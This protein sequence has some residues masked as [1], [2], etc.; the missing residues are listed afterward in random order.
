MEFLLLI[1]AVMIGLAILDAAAAQ[2]GVDSSL[3]ED[4]HALL[5]NAL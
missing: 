1:L 4:P 3:D 5:H 2:V